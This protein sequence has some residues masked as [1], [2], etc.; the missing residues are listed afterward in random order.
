MVSPTKTR[1]QATVGPN[2]IRNVPT[3]QWPPQASSGALADH[4]ARMIRLVRNAWSSGVARALR[5]NRALDAAVFAAVR[6][7]TG[8][9]LT[10]G[11]CAILFAFFGHPLIG[12]GFGPVLGAAGGVALDGPPPADPRALP[13][14]SRKDEGPIPSLVAGLVTGI[15]GGAAIGFLYAHSSAPASERPSA[16]ALGSAGDT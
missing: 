10:S 4:A 16:S 1:Q 5:P 13:F 12:L 2:T 14:D 9:I 11:L 7:V 15:G 8:G 6:A 3:G